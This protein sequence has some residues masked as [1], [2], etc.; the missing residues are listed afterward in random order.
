MVYSR[1]IREERLRELARD[2]DRRSNLASPAVQ[3]SVSAP[4]LPGGEGPLVFNGAFMA[5]TC[6]T[7]E[8]RQA[9]PIS[10]APGYSRPATLVS[11]R[12]IVQQAQDLYQM[13]VLQMEV[14]Q[15]LITGQRPLTDPVSLHSL[16]GARGDETAEL[17][18][19]LIG[20][21][22]LSEREIRNVLSIIRDAFAKPET[23][24]TRGRSAKACQL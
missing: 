8:G 2:L 19:N 4:C 21:N 22:A 10:S 1:A 18:T 24:A 14:L 16:R 13:E 12:S 7:A 3:F 17:I 11:G 15:A 23:L 20:V 6:E 9:F 5:Q